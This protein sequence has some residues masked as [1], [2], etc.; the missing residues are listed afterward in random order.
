ML[1]LGKQRCMKHSPHLEGTQTNRVGDSE[2]ISVNV[3]LYRKAF[4]T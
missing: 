1:G 2:S 4:G 3:S